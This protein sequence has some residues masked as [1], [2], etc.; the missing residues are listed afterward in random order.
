MLSALVAVA[1]AGC[2]SNTPVA[3]VQRVANAFGTL[4]AAS[5][6][7]FDDLAVAEREQGRNAADHRARQRSAGDSTLDM[8]P[9]PEAVEVRV[10]NVTVQDSFCVADSYY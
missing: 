7:L 3:E 5:A 1:C 2:A 6:P 10:G 4:N 8:G 9:C